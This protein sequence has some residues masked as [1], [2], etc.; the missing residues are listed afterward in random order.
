MRIGIAIIVGLFALSL[1]AWL[2]PNTYPKYVFRYELTAEIETPNGLRSGSSV[3]EATYAMPRKDGSVSQ[4]LFGESLVVD[5]GGGKN[6]IITLTN[7]YGHREDKLNAIY[8]P[9]DL[10]DIYWNVKRDEQGLA[11]TERT[12]A[13]AK[14]SPAK[15][16]PLERLPLAVTFTDPR[17]PMSIVEVDPRDLAATY[18]SGYRLRRVT[19]EASSKSLTDGVLEKLLPW[20]RPKMESHTKRLSGDEPMPRGLSSRENIA[21]FL[22]SFELKSRGTG[23]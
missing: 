6:F 15:E 22:N 9:L 11:T 13:A 10:F 20:L 3:V 14:L 23:L 17:D 5:L 2:W 16:V 8:L 1:T 7:Q 4:G 18:G 21:F 12:F 19:I